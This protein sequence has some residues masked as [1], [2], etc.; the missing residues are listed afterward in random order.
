[1][2][3]R[4]MK[5][6]TLSALALLLGSSY[7]LAGGG[8]PV[9]PIPESSPPTGRPS[10]VLD[11]AKCEAIWNITEREGDALLAEKAAPFVTNFH[12]VDTDGDGK[13]SLDEFKAGC[14]QGWVEEGT[15]SRL[16]TKKA[17][18]DVPKE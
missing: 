6:A 8:A 14:K 10:A 18:P 7:A 5:L 11:D 9:P 17:S 3:V 12:M 13:V 4:Q 16:P 2:G 1:M 15:A